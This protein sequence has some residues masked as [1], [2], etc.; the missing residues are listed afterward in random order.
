MRFLAACQSIRGETIFYS[1]ASTQH[2]RTNYKNGCQSGNERRLCDI[3]GSPRRASRSVKQD[4]AVVYHRWAFPEVWLGSLQGRST[5]RW[6]SPCGGCALARAG[7]L[8]LEASRAEP[9]LVNV[10]TGVATHFPLPALCT[11]SSAAQA[12]L[13]PTGLLCGRPGLAVVAQLEGCSL[14]LQTLAS[15]DTADLAN[16][17][18]EALERHYSLVA[19][20]RRYLRCTP[21]NTCFTA[22]LWK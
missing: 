15:S 2:F 17:K 20:S 13:W 16:R 18:S 22:L 9:W 3:R 19:T 12:R 14:Q 1:Y 11:A 8:F 10:V 21:E 5:G 4:A 6:P 7:R